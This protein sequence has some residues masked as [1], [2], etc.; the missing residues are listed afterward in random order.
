V[1]NHQ[2]FVDLHVHTNASDSTFT[3]A[4]LIEIAKEKGFSALGITD[5]DNVSSLTIASELGKTAG[6]EIVPGVELS[7]EKEAEEVHIL[8]Y[9]I[10][11]KEDWFIE[12]LAMI[13]QVREKRAGEIVRKLN[14]IGIELD[15]ET[16]KEIAGE[17]SI[18]RLHIARALVKAGYVRDIQQAFQLYIGDN[19]PAY[20]KKFPLTPGEAIDMI[21][22]VK[23]LS[24]LAHPGLLKNTDLISHVIDAGIDAIEVFYPE[25]SDTQTRDFLELAH[26]NRL[27]VT[28]GSDCHGHAKEE[29]MLGIIKLPYK[30]LE[31][32]KNRK[33]GTDTI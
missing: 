9:Y 22:G 18:G 29:K 32:L 3:P 6:I 2:K 33:I 26:K 21:R 20:V 25:H 12:K 8:G 10:L 30:Y 23:G 24:C 7:A 31:A 1:K 28:G 17:G 19:K 5:H 27:L 15:F 4:Q 11:W 16:I 13:S 14:S